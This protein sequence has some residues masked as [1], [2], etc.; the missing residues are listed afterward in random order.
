ML[1]EVPDDGSDKRG[2]DSEGLADVER[3]SDS[4]DDTDE[5]EENHSP[6][7]VDVQKLDD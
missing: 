1:Y 5:A 6:E 4:G 7:D 2:S 3:K